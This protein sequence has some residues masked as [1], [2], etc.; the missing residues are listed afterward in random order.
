MN[1]VHTSFAPTVSAADALHAASLL[2]RPWRWRRGPAASA[3]RDALA[4]LLGKP[5]LLLVDS[6]RNALRLALQLLGVGTDD[7]VI[8]QAFTCVSVPG[9]VLWVGAKPVYADIDPRTY[10]LSPA[11]LERRITPRTRAL[12]IQHTFGL[13]ADLDAL[14][15]IAREHKLAVIEDCAHALGAT[16][17][18]QPV[19]TFGDAAIFSFGR[20]KVIS[21]VFGG[22]LVINRAELIDALKAK[23]DQ[24]KAPPLWWVARQLLH[25]A[26]APTIRA[27]YFWGGREA[28]RLLLATKTLS[29]ALTAQEKRGGQPPLDPS[30]L[31]NALAARA[32][33]QLRRLDEFHERRR[34]LAQHYAESL[35]GVPD[36][37]L[38][39]VPP[40]G[41]TGLTTG[42][43]PAWLRYAVRV[44]NRARLY[45]AARRTGIILRDPWYD[46][47]VAPRGC[48]MRALRYVAGSCPEAER[49]SAQVVNL[50][51]SPTIGI[52]EA[53]RVIR[54]VRDVFPASPARIR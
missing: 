47:V 6:G 23:S 14:L 42:R 49:A 12:I 24:L 39:G 29:R 21:S 48:D 46:M 34:A 37:A 54:V 45:A 11:S 22:A 5:N 9:P 38:L 53:D 43:T 17:R 30:T 3:L 44:P 19:G 18:G 52:P 7:E 33:H 36:V 41:S 25:T 51:T 31:A 20:D 10:T 35:A 13:P 16:Y 26:L 27:T 2:L 1:V 50:P 32:L 28:L 15:R 4:K 40:D 8:L